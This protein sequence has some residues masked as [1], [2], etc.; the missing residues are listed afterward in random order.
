MTDAY[1]Q[2]T[3]MKNSLMQAYKLVPWRR[4]MQWIVLSLL[5]IVTVSLVAWLYLAVAAKTSI[6]GREYQDYQSQINKSEQSIA[7][8]QTNLAE[9]TS[10]T[11]MAKRAKAL[12]FKELNPGKFDYML[13]PNYAGKPSAK[14]A[15]ENLPIHTDS[16][17]VTGDFTESLWDWMYSSYI[18]P[19]ITK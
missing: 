2:D 19:A 16:S 12:G 10:S 9:I 17:V 1:L 5:G 3:M 15:P 11:Q 18:E 14:L 4:Q 8:M 6:A 7:A 13:I